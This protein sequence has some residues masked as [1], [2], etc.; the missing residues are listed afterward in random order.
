[1]ALFALVSVVLAAPSV[2]AAGFSIYEHSARASGMAGAWTAQANDAAANWYNPAGLVWLEGSEFQIGGNIITAGGDTEI[3]SNDIRFGLTEPTTFEMVGHTGT[4][5]HAYYS[6]KI[7]PNVAFG[8][9]VNTPFGLVTDWDVRPVTF[10]ARTSELQTFVFN[11]NLAFRMTRNTAVAVGVMYYDA[12]ILNFGREIP[13]DLDGNPLNGFEVIGSSNLTG[14]GEETGWNVALHHNK[15]NPNTNTGWS[16]GFVYRSDVTIGLDGTVDFEDFGPLAP[17]FTDRSGTADLKLPDTAAVGVAWQT[18]NDWTF[19]VDVAWQG[20]SVFDTL[21]VD[22]ENN[23]PGLVEDINLREDWDDAFSYRF[24]AEKRVGDHAWR[25]GF[26]F[27]EQTV[28]E[29]TLRPSIPDA[30][31]YGPTFGYGRNAGRFSY[32]LYYLPL[33]FSDS[34]AVGT[35]EGL[36]QADYE[37][38]AH[39]AGFT[40]RIKL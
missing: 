12:E 16:F 17:I 31:R 39:L 6:R 38:F 32:D 11:A 15:I 40:L 20:W 3:T 8:I 4:P 33:F 23:V 10:T 22:I 18:A 30:D 37:T 24:G 13:I 26:V 21:F 19:E 27:D 5:V 35:E 14:T 7:N 29:D 28:P 1:M 25:F 36:I 9:G 34:T 2:W